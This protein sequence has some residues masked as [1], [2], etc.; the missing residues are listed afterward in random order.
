MYFG[1]VQCGTIGKLKKALLEGLPRWAILSISLIGS[2]VTEV[3][4]HEELLTRLVA[5]IVL[6]RYRRFDS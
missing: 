1:N 6:S 5:K 3:L 4:C 2:A